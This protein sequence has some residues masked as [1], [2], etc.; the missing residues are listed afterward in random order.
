MPS[1][2]LDEIAPRLPLFAD[3][4]AFSADA[5]LDHDS[6]VVQNPLDIAPV[7]GARS[8]RVGVGD[9]NCYTRA[10]VTVFRGDSMQFYDQWETPVVIISDGPYGVGGFRGDPPNS[11]DLAAWYAPHVATWSKR[12]TPQTTLWFWNTEL[13]WATVHPVLLRHGWTYRCCH[14]WNKGVGHIA[15]NANSKSLRK[16]PVVTEVCAQYVREP[17]FGAGGVPMSMREWLRYEWERTGIPFSV[18]N[19]VCGVRNAATRKYFTKD[20]LWYYPPVEHFERLVLYANEHG[21]P[22]GCPYFSSNGIRPMSGAEWARMRAKFHCEVGVTNVWTAPAVRGSERLKSKSKCIHSNQKPLQLIEL[23]IRASSDSGDLVWE[24]FG[25]LCSAAVASLN[26]GRNCASA[27]I[28][29]EFFEIAVERLK[30]HVVKSSH[31]G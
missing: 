12:A 14:I 4:T 6:A 16:F 30:N 11:H 23:S 2:Y 15:G 22:S 5:I 26:L 10:G 28:S 27:E 1:E 18:T 31:K 21:N 7:T 17:E 8:Q 29:D 3:D 19:S 20:H 25:G 9:I 24:P 13:G